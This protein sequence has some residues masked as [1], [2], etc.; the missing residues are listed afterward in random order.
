MK[1][2]QP[3]LK[4]QKAWGFA[5]FEVTSYMLQFEGHWQ[6]T[7]TLDSETNTFLLTDMARV[8]IFV[9]SQTSVPQR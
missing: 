3:V 7:W 6:K 5:L 2:L 9:Q 4:L 1:L 8:S